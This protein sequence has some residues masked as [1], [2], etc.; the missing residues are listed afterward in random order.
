MLKNILQKIVPEKMTNKRA[1]CY[2]ALVSLLLILPQLLTRSMVISSDSLFHF[3]RFYDVSQQIQEG[4]FQY[5]I[6]MYGFQQSGRVVNALYGALMGYLQGLLVW[7]SPSWFGYQLLSNFLLFFLASSAMFLLLKKC[8]V[9]SNQA[10]AFSI[11]YVTTYSIQYWVIRQGFS[12]WGAALFPLCLIPVVTLL[13][14]HKLKVLETGFFVALMAQVH[15]FSTVL[16]VIIYLCSF[17]FVIF[18]DKQQAKDLFSAAIRAVLVFILLTLN[19]WY[20]FYE[21]YTHNEILPPF[22]NQTIYFNTITSHSS[23]WITNSW[24]LVVIIPTITF[25]SIYHWRALAS[26]DRFLLIAALGFLAAATNLVPWKFLSEKDLAI[27]NLIQFPFRFVVPATVLFIILLA[28]HY[29]QLGKYANKFLLPLLSLVLIQA[30]TLS[31][32]ECQA[33]QTKDDPFKSGKHTYLMSDDPTLAKEAFFSADKQVALK[34]MQK[35]TPDYVPIYRQSKN[36][37]YDQYAI[38]IIFENDNFVKE[39]VDKKLV[40]QWTGQENQTI[41]LPVVV[42]Q[43]TQLTLNGKELTHA[44]LKLSEIGTPTFENHAGENNLV[45]SYPYPKYFI[46]VLLLSLTLL[47]LLAAYILYDLLKN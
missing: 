3:N 18:K 15:L 2:F 12:S 9:K 46:A 37:K 36:N 20:S 43:N 30:L 42:Y 32:V 1:F 10:V 19:I 29:S 27:V 38:N 41:N 47:I 7:L 17:I 5:F 45:V 44:D 25:F 33:W 39:V 35:S 16:L 40:I 13:T 21:L 4:N 22:I 8:Q 34:L 23:H 14:Q 28:R 11:F 31:A 24:L 6:N 26:F